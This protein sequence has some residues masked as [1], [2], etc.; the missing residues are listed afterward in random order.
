[1]NIGWLHKYYAYREFYNNVAK[2]V[3]EHKEHCMKESNSCSG[4]EWTSDIAHELAKIDVEWFK[5]IG[6]DNEK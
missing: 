2:I 4:L 1:M 6:N 3:V 5:H